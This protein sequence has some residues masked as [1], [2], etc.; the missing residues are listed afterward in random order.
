MAIKLVKKNQSEVFGTSFLDIISCGFGAMLV[1][2]ILA[3]DSE[4]ETDY[5]PT[6]I[7]QA[8]PEVM[9][10]P[11]LTQNSILKESVVNFQSQIEN[12]SMR[13]ERERIELQSSQLV[14]RIKEQSIKTSISQPV[15][16]GTIDSIYS[17]GV[18]VGQDYIIFILD[19]SGS[20]QQNW[21]IVFN[22]IQNVISA[23]PLV[24]GI[25]ILN[26]NGEYLLDGY[27]GIWIP[28]SESARNRAFEKLRTW[29][30]YS[31]SS[32]AEG[33]EKALRTYAKSDQSLSIYVL[34]DDYTG[35][36]YD[37]VL[38]TVDRW[39]MDIDGNRMA[40]IHGIGF[41]WGLTDR[42]ATLMREVA[43][44]NNGVFLGLNP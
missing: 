36:S 26:D 23:H 16:V 8:Q 34:G 32:P 21:N 29:N 35:N 27:A 14:L 44:Y 7:I 19:T 12:L 17:G 28:D 39:N 25:Q 6:E 30:S 3:K 37:N 43:F 41:P 1:L 42:F 15:Q 11:I 9:I 24:K 13:L 20:M 4:E 2:L 33:L 31:N 38:S 5:I 22:T 10:E 18:P 40:S